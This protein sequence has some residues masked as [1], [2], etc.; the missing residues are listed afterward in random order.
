MKTREAV[1][2]RL[3]DLCIKEGK[4]P[5]QLAYDAGVPHSTVKSIIN[6]HS[7]NPGIVSIKKLCDGLNISIYDF[8]MDV[9]FRE[10][11]QEIE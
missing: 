4:S 11:E 7:K 8:F 9:R 6:G 5:C 2:I 3:E 10:L 1:V